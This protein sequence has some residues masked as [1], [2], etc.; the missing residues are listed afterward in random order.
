MSASLWRKELADDRDG[1]YSIP[2][3]ELFQKRRTEYWN[4]VCLKPPAEMNEDIAA[5]LWS[6]IAPGRIRDGFYVER[7][8]LKKLASTPHYVAEVEMINIGKNDRNDP[9]PL[10]R[11]VSWTMRTDYVEKPAEV[12]ADG[13]RIENKAFEPILGMVTYEPVLIF[14]TTRFVTSIPAWL[15]DFTEKCTNASAFTID[16][17]ECE[18]LTCKLEGLEIG[19]VEVT[20]I[21]GKEVRYR[22]VP[23]TVSYKKTTWIEERLNV[24]LTEYIPPQGQIFATNLYAI[25]AQRRPC[26]DASGKPV[27]KPVPL[28]PDG[29]QIRERVQVGVAAD[30]TV[31]FEWRLKEKLDKKDINFCKFNMLKRLDFNLLL[32]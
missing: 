30:R 12:D 29:R 4:L 27:E 7:L 8:K 10:R 28:T 17:F 25:P 15:K 21:D 19:P 16:G 22:E 13:N 6:D 1:E 31:L 5:A 26:V 20:E 24:G 11:P 9:N 32:T 18:P 3:G 2:I 23:L 14:S